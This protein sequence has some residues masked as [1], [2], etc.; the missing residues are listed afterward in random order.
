LAESSKA[1]ILTGGIFH[2]FA[3]SSAALAGILREL[4]LEADIR[5][6]VES[7][8]GDLA[9]GQYRLLVVN[10]LRWRML[11]H[12]K[13][14]PFR[15]EWAMSLSL[16]GRQAI[17]DF[18]HGG[19][20]LLGL[21]TAS[22]CFDDWPQWG[23]VLGVRWRWGCSFHPP[24][25]PVQ[26][27]VNREAHVVTRNVTDF[28]LEDEVYQKLELAGDAVA[29]ATASVAGEDAAHPVIWAHRYGRG[30]VIYDALGHDAA[31][32]QQ[33]PHA[34]FMHQACEWILKGEEA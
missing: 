1:L 15:A 8:L 10:A 21:H 31:S 32:L 33:P 11:D 27:K 34:Q 7:A 24:L 5:M 22:I 13:Y 30:R 19:G 18:V 6:D 17:V 23:E 26:V 29:L 4:G 3:E 16:A 25:G 20:G 28:E 12:E 9:R 14:I 2:P